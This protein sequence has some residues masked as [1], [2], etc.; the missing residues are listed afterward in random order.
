MQE[1]EEDDEEDE[2]EDDGDLETG[3][4]D[5]D[6]GDDPD[7]EF[8]M[9]TAAAQELVSAIVSDQ[10]PKEVESYSDEGSTSGLE[11]LAV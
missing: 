1:T 4:G 10:V 5:G 7:G 6:D 8:A 2:D 9:Q 11:E 3:E